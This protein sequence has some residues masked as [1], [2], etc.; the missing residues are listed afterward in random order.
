MSFEEEIRKL[1][2][3]LATMEQLVQQLEADQ[4]QAPEL[5]EELAE[6][7]KGATASIER[8]RR[9]A[10]TEAVAPPSSDAPAA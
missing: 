4:E 10:E 9:A 3:H 2:E 1:E 7:A 8:A 5:I 6:H